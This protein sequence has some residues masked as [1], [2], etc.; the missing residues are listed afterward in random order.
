[1][2]KGSGDKNSWRFAEDKKQNKAENDRRLIFNKGNCQK[3]SITIYFL[4]VCG[5]PSEDDIKIIKKISLVNSK[6]KFV[7]FYLLFIYLHAK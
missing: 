3:L 5:L 4:G 2:R 7:I 1:M 6:I